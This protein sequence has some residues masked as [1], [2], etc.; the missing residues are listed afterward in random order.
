M[1]PI[2]RRS[3]FFYLTHLATFSGGLL[4]LFCEWRAFEVVSLF[5]PIWLSSSVLF[6]E[7]NES[8]AFLRTLP[9]TDRAIVRAK[10]GILLSA[11]AAYWL[12][13]TGLTIA[14]SDRMGVGYPTGVFVTLTWGASLLLA[15][16][17]Q[18]AIWRF[19]QPL[20]TWFIVAFMAWYLVAGIPPYIN[21]ITSLR[22]GEGFSESTAIL[23]LA[24][25]PGITLALTIAVVLA[26]FY[27]LM[28]VG[29][30]I[31]RSSEACL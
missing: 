1:V 18:I 20:M 19:G 5:I 29:V 11:S 10:F 27:G 13:V 16:L 7:H 14:L 9:V 30:R 4:W 12:A 23:W 25:T 3:S 24:E 22:R 8:Y 6:S 28:Q 17:W 2:I 21:F 31:K 26:A 15:A